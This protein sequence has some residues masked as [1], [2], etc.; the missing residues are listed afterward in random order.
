MIYLSIYIVYLS[1]SLS[2][3]LYFSLSLFLRCKI[4][5]LEQGVDQTIELARLLQSSDGICL[6]YISIYL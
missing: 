3:S 1:T 2:L 6:S 4:R 5:L